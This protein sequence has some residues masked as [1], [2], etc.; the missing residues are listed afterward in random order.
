MYG[1]LDFYKATAVLIFVSE[2]INMH[3]EYSFFEK[4]N[5]KQIRFLFFLIIISNSFKVNREDMWHI[6]HLRDYT[7]TCM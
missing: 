1:F 7:H 5:N 3:I 4:T 6:P 2:V